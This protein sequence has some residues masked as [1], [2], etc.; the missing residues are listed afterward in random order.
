MS[1]SIIRLTSLDYSSFHSAGLSVSILAS[2]SS[3]A[4]QTQKSL[5][6]KYVLKAVSASSDETVYAI[7]STVVLDMADVAALTVKSIRLEATGGSS[8][9][10]Q[11][12]AASNDVRTDVE[13]SAAAAAGGG[14]GNKAGSRQLEQAS[15]AWTSASNSRADMLLEDGGTGGGGGGGGGGNRNKTAPLK[16]SID[17]WD[18]FK[19]NEKLFNVKG[20][21]DEN[22]YTT[23][24][25]KTQMTSRKIKEAERITREIETSVS[26]NMHVA[27]ERGQ[28]VEGDYDEED[29]YSGVLK[30]KDPAASAGGGITAKAQKVMNYAA[31]A[32]AKK[33]TVPPGFNK[34][35]PAASAAAI[36]P[37]KANANGK[38]TEEKVPAAK[39]EPKATT[40]DTSKVEETATGP[41]EESKKE[42]EAKKAEAPKSK[43]SASAKSF[44][45]SIKAKEW[46][47]PTVGAPPPAPPGGDPSMAGRHPMSHSQ[48]P[49]HYL[50]QGMGQPGTLW[51]SG[52][53][54]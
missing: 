29:L 9:S 31:A 45:L 6:N 24:L 28:T 5:E 51:T 16:G 49:P 25:D 2:A 18:Q 10:K 8:S 50:Q 34:T 43:L 52:W 36:K 38:A 21:Y 1:S 32:A 42:E 53:V 11:A 54:L 39:D 12:Q 40:T 4:S 48:P 44:S 30:P 26:T 35:V 22:L 33:D 3:S 17:G 19:A 7:G 14:A 15:S 13:I 37:N 27:E 47:P 46:T 23:A 41:G 20:S